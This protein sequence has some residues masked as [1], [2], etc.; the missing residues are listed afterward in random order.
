MRRAFKNAF[1]RDKA[2]R[3]TDGKAKEEAAGTSEG[4]ATLGE[5]AN[6]PPQ[7][8]ESSSTEGTVSLSENAT[9]LAQKPDLYSTKGVTGIKVVAQP[10]DADLEY[11]QNPSYFY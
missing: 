8:P 11:A 6:P 1:G 7:E 9:P 10:I 2:D 4:I 5:G 3:K